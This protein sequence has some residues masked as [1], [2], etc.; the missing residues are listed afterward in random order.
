M[1]CGTCASGDFVRELATFLSSPWLV[2][3]LTNA[4]VH[5]VNAQAA[6]TAA[7][8]HVGCVPSLHIVQVAS[9]RLC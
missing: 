5:H 4:C 2:L 9:Q 3:P 1:L 8:G 6:A 7:A